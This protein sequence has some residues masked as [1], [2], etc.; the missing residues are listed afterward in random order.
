[1]SDTPKTFSRADINAARDRRAA[2]K[3]ARAARLFHQLQLERFNP[4]GTDKTH[5]IQDD[6]PTAI[7]PAPARSART[8]VSPAATPAAP[9]RT[10]EDQRYAEYGRN[11]IPHGTATAPDKHRRDATAGALYRYPHEAPYAVQLQITGHIAR[12][13]PGAPLA[14]PPTLRGFWCATHERVAR[15]AL[16]QAHRAVRRHGLTH[17]ADKSGFLA[18]HCGWYRHFCSFSAWLL[19][20]LPE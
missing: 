14:N 16:H 6:P 11:R 7:P 8:H 10:P 19:R 2:S 12:S 9:W 3:L 20:R 5:R 15:L 18:D 4:L 1:M 17:I 13:L